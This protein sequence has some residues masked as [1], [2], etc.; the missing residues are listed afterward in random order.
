M[1]NMRKITVLRDNHG[2]LATVRETEATETWELEWTSTPDAG[3]AYH[4][5]RN[6][7]SAVLRNGGE[8]LLI[9]CPEDQLAVRERLDKWPDS[10]MSKTG[11]CY[12]LQLIA[13]AED[14]YIHEDFDFRTPLHRITCPTCVERIAKKRTEKREEAFGKGNGPREI[15]KHTSL[16]AE[17][18]TRLAEIEENL[19]TDDFKSSPAKGES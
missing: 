16:V 7:E 2:F 8:V 1:E 14:G 4:M 11:E 9:N 5:L 18:Y 19:N 6:A 3:R 10:I 15:A 13:A 12:H 17:A